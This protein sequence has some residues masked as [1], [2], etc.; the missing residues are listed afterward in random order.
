MSVRRA[1]V[2]AAA[3]LAEL[4]AACGAAFLLVAATGLAV[5]SGWR[6]GLAVLAGGIVAAVFGAGACGWLGLPVDLISLPCLIGAMAAGAALSVLDG[7]QR[8]VPALVAMALLAVVAS[9]WGGGSPGLFAVIVA[10]PAVAATL[11]AG[12]AISRDQ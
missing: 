4:L 12:L 7:G 1:L 3:H 2:L 8:L 6:S 5:L 10:A 9:I 11:T